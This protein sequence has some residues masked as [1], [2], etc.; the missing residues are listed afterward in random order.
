MSPLA[1]LTNAITG[2]VIKALRPCRVSHALASPGSDP[3]LLPVALKLPPDQTPPPLLVR[4]RK[5]FGTW[6]HLAPLLFATVSLW[7]IFSLFLG[8]ETKEKKSKKRE[9]HSPFLL[10]ARVA[11]LRSSFFFFSALQIS[12]TSSFSQGAS[13]K[14]LLTCIS[15]KQL[16]RPDSASPFCTVRR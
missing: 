5:V 8:R 3:S 12:Y 15:R 13:A 1:G 6:G 14:L 2:C 9:L 4:L 10:S 11:Y 16:D 7:E